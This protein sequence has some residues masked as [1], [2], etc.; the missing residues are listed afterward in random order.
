V[1]VLGEHQR[2][3]A[4][5]FGGETG[6]EVDKLART[7][8]EAGPGGVPLLVACPVRFLGRIASLHDIGGDHLGVILEPQDAQADSTSRPLRLSAVSDIDPG[9]PA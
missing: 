9:H 2:D 4:E 7:T 5:L 6:D 3:L 1:H 8:W